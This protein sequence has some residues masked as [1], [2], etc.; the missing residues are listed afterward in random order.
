MAGVLA[1]RVVC[2]APLGRLPVLAAYAFDPALWAVV[3]GLPETADR[4]MPGL[5][6]AAASP[7]TAIN[8]VL[9][10]AL[11]L[12]GWGPY[13][14]RVMRWFTEAALS[15]AAFFMA[16]QKRSAPEGAVS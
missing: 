15:W 8:Q 9:S 16:R 13:G 3:A 4:A 5:S 2:T 1:G 6:G 12:R 10:L 7:A 14:V 11:R